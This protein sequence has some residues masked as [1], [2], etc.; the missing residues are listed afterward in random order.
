MS[1]FR[2]SFFF[3]SGRVA[4]SI[5]FAPIVVLCLDSMSSPGVLVFLPSFC[6]CGAS[7]PVFSSSSFLGSLSMSLRRI[8]PSILPV[9][10]PW[11]PAHG[12]H[13]ALP[14]VCSLCRLFGP[15]WFLR[16]WSACFFRVSGLSA[17][18][19]FSSFRRISLSSVSSCLLFVSVVY[20]CASCHVS[21]V[22]VFIHSASS[23]AS[24]PGSWFSYFSSCASASATSSAFSWLLCGWSICFFCLPCISECCCCLVCRLYLQLCLLFHCSRLCYVLVP[25]APLLQHIPP[26]ILQVIF[27]IRPALGLLLALALRRRFLLPFFFSFVSFWALLCGIS[28]CFFRRGVSPVFPSSMQLFIFSSSLVLLFVSFSFWEVSPF[29]CFVCYSFF[30]SFSSL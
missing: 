7:L 26:P 23:R 20:S 4:F 18:C 13:V 3:S 21:S 27:L 2:C 11:C 28:L 30:F 15:S 19:G 9:I 16:G 1:I 29:V 24:S 8:C 6:V 10:A 14:S 5:G 12:L 25:P 22:Y 17:F